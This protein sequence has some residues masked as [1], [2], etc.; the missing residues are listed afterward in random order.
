MTLGDM[1]ELG[2]TEKWG[3]EQGCRLPGQE[4]LPTGAQLSCS[5]R[6]EVGHLHVLCHLCA[7]RLSRQQ[8]L[9]CAFL[10]AAASAKVGKLCLRDP[11]LTARGASSQGSEE[12][13]V[14]LR[15]TFR[16]TVHGLY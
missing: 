10:H 7:S 16:K 13:A 11:P 6:I 3:A 9:A 8:W 1:A 14:W 4:K 15:Q 2:V 12:Q 5:L